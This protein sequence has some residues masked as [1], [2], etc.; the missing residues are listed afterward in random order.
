MIHYFNNIC[1]YSVTLF[2]WGW[3][4]SYD[5]FNIG[6]IQYSYNAGGITGYTS[7]STIQ[8]VYNIGHVLTLNRYGYDSG[9]IKNREVVGILT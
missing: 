1:N 7:N 5:S 8:N 2:I 6:E 3:L 9:G 4:S